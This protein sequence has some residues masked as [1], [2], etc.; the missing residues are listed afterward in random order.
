MS[1]QQARYR[2]GPLERRGLLFGLQG[3]QILML[4]IGL[5]TAIFMTG[6]FGQVLG[7]PGLV[8]GLCTMGGAVFVAFWPVNGRHISQ[9][10]APT[11][12]FFWRRFHHEDTFISRAPVEGRT[13]RRET[14]L[15]LPPTLD[16]FEILPYPVTGGE[17]GV[18]HHKTE[19]TYTAVLSVRGRSFA[20]LDEMQ[21]A[22]LLSQW[23]DVLSGMARE[24]SPIRRVQWIERTLP[25]PGDGMGEYLREAIALPH[26]TPAVRSYLNLVDT[27]GPATQHHECFVAI[28]IDGI[29]AG[30][31]I[32]NAGGGDAGACAVLARDIFALASRLQSAELDIVGML[33]PRLL[34]ECIRVAFDPKVRDQ[35]AMRSIG[36][37]RFSGVD[38]NQAWP[39][40]T[41]NEWDHYRTD[42]AYHATFWV[43]EWPRTEVGP[44][45]LAPLIMQAWVNRTISV[46]IEPVPPLRAQ[47]E[48]EW[49]R[50]HDQANNELRAKHGF[51]SSMRRQRETENVIRRE[52]EL[53]DG[54]ADIR[55]S[56]YVT[57]SAPTKDELDSAASEVEQQAGQSRLVLRRMSAEQDVA[58]TYTLPLCRGLK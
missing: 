39:M 43:A 46:T 1:E 55:F 42:S 16:G 54:H 49:A 14:R 26:T 25:D 27:A 33:T 23:A 17:L 18:L 56:G 35:L 2:F 41:K 6:I 22:R 37:P 53:A 20:L 48:A 32:R 30:R 9:W 50:T 51:L 19:G 10:I 3:F 47:R 45:F 31:L 11:A 7:T 34:A 29:T 44:D 8:L 15:D 21:K 28:Q 38:V 12:S 4:V 36:D 57:V 52:E 40:V 13:L 24:G 5:I 58:F